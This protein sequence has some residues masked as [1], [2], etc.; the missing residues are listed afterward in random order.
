MANVEAKS[1]ANADVPEITD[2]MVSAGVTELLR[3]DIYPNSDMT[4]P[5]LDTWR[6]ALRDAFNA[7]LRSR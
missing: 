7:M 2:E 4:G 1:I 5:S 6:E 3:H